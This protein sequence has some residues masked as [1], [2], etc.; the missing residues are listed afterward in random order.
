M[1]T[2]H[3]IMLGITA[4]IALGLI[5]AASGAFSDESYGNTLKAY[6]TAIN[7]EKRAKT[8]FEQTILKRC[9]SERSLLVEALRADITGEK[10]L[11][12]EERDRI[13]NKLADFEC[14]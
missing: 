7:A 12:Q 8:A 6:Q 5:G 14:F 13:E 3:K 11:L 9:T 1:A 10:K 4:I 2:K